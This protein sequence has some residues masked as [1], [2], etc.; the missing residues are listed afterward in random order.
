MLLCLRIEATTGGPIVKLGAN[1]P[2][3][4]RSWQCR[5][6]N[7]LD[8]IHSLIAGTHPYLHACTVAG[9]SGIQPASRWQVSGV[10]NAVMITPME[11]QDSTRK[12]RR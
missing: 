8:N 12:K 10:Q 4:K 2:A 7:T 1:V 9:H 6:L 3:V 11:R 5:R